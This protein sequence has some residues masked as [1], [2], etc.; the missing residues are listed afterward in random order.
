[1]KKQSREDKIQSLLRHAMQCLSTKKY[2]NCADNIIHFLKNDN[3]SMMWLVKQ[4]DNI[5]K[6]GEK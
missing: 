3:I 2:C 4:Y 6:A 1:M 5:K